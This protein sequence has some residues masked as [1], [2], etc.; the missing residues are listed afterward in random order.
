MVKVAIIG[1][2]VLHGF[3]FAC[4]SCMLDQSYWMPY[5]VA[6]EIFG[7]GIILWLIAFRY[8]KKYHIA[9]FVTLLFSIFRE[10]W[11]IICYIKGINTSDTNLTS[12]LFLGLLPVIYYTLFVPNGRLTTFLDKQLKRISL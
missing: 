12:I 9:A 6:D 2:T 10:V 7:G 3:F 5:W 1:Y 11:N 4:Q 8:S